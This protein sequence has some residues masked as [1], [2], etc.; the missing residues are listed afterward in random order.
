MKK[1]LL[2]IT[3][4]LLLIVMTLTVVACGGGSNTGGGGGGGNTGGSKVSVTGVSIEPTTLSIEAGDSYTLTATVMPSNATNKAVNWSSSNPAIVRVEN[5]VITAMAQGSSQISVTTVDGNYTASITVTVTPGGV[6][7]SQISLDQT[8]LTLSPGASATIIATVNPVEATNKEVTWSSSNPEVA[9]VSN[10]VVTAVGV[11]NATIT[12]TTVVGTGTAECYISVV[13]PTFNF[14]LNDDET[15]YV[16]TSYN[17]NG[18]KT[19]NIPDT[20]EGLP[21][22]EINMGSLASWGLEQINIPESIVTINSGI[23]FSNTPLNEYEGGKYIGNEQNPYLWF[24]GLIDSEATSITLHEDTVHVLAKSLKESLLE[25]INLNEGLKY[26]HEQAIHSCYNL[27]SITLPSTLEYIGNYAF[28]FSA[29]TEIVLPDSVKQIGMKAFYDLESLTSVTFGSGIEIVE[30]EAF[31]KSININEV[32]IDSLA[33]W[34][35]IEFSQAANPLLYNATLIVNGQPLTDLVIPEG[36]TKIND[37]AFYGCNSITSLTISSSVIEIG[38][39]AFYDCKSLATALVPETVTKMGEGVFGNC[40]GLQS[41]TLPFIG[42]DANNPS[43][44]NSSNYG[45]P[46]T[47]ILT[48][49][50]EIIAG[51]FQYAKVE[52]VI[53][54]DSIITIGENAFD[55]CQILKTITLGTGVTTIGAEAFDGC[56]SLKGVYVK[57]LSAFYNI[58]FLNGYASNPLYY[59]HNIYLNNA[60]VTEINFGEILGEEETSITKNPFGYAYSVRK[61]IIPERVTSCNMNFNFTYGDY[62]IYNASSISISYSS[63]YGNYY[64]P[65]YSVSKLVIDNGFIFI[66]KSGY[67]QETYYLVGYVGNDT[68]VVLPTQ[69]PS[70]NADYYIDSYAFFNNDKITSISYNEQAESLNKLVGIK[71]YA[72]KGCTSLTSVKL[73]DSV[74][75]IY[76]QAF[77]ECYALES[78]KLSANLEDLEDWAFS[79]CTSLKSIDIPGTVETIDSY[80]FYQC[81]DLTDVTLGNGIININSDAFMRSGISLLDIPDSVSYIG[82]SAFSGCSNLLKVVF[83]T[84]LSNIGNNAFSGCTKLVEVINFST[85]PVEKGGET[86]GGVAFYALEVLT[87]LPQNDNLVFDY[88]GFVFFCYTE[89]GVTTNYLIAYVGDETEIVL[90]EDFGGESYEIY[91]NFINGNDKITSVV[92]SDGVT[93]VG[94]TAFY[95]CTKL[96][97]ITVGKNVKYFGYEAFADSQNLSSNAISYVNF[98]GTIDDWVQIEFATKGANPANATDRLYINGEEVTEVILTTATKICDYVLYSAQYVTKV[99]IPDTV[100]SIGDQPFTTYTHTLRF[101]YYESCA[102]LGNDENPYL[103]FVQLIYSNTTECAIHEDTK[104]ILSYAFSWCHQL[105]TINF[106]GTVAE[107]ESITKN[108]N[109]DFQMNTA[110]VVCTDG[111]VSVPQANA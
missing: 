42:T 88:D 48:G 49:G 66:D 91:K 34:L 82:A 78:V 36:V 98:T 14:E 74:K 31:N 71:D 41:L 63:Y 15:G 90:P 76:S 59:A 8:S 7:P 67:S 79:N 29:L 11:G 55:E 109:W 93:A 87:E 80:A 28:A 72:F 1:I 21:V 73:P 62:E 57:D 44:F 54:P 111:T 103:V 23:S 20:Y 27:T 61:Y 104:F 5:G 51:A 92:I 13:E 10:G 65:T 58:E 24:I 60:L 12:V 50:T 85:L 32:K 4:P 53:L 102:Y 95:D 101:N 108:A 3:V 9:T 110:T 2:A 26:I 35:N 68:D 37:N 64:T 52:N 100:V 33:T 107:F 56:Q 94:E 77:A 19:L 84:G 45:T 89:G 75:R 22:V 38:E 70:V 40:T 86:C 43:R 16:L 105:T 47:F 83:G 106:N 46:T 81:Y 69:S 39:D 18:A 25:E 30:Q 17:A 6:L 99:I 96:A 97:S